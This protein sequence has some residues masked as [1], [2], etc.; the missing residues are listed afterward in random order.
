MQKQSELP[1]LSLT[2]ASLAIAMA[3][4]LFVFLTELLNF[5]Y[6][7]TIATSI[8]LLIV[9][10]GNKDAFRF[11]IKPRHLLLGLTS[12]LLLYG[13]FFAGFNIARGLSL[14]TEGARNVYAFR[15]G[16]PISII[17]A[18]LLFPISP[19]EEIFWRGLIQ[20]GL[21]LKLGSTTGYIAATLSYSLVHLPTFNAPLMLVALIGGLAWGF[22]YN[23]TKS[24]TPSVIS[25]L[26]F[27][28]MIFVLLP[29]A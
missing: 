2:L 28:E 5:W 9:L 16:L 15:S 7:L 3:L 4:W 18:L 19:A 22:L 27:N 17:G 10:A 8:F 1:G 13:F 20:K 29:I 25:H 26:I 12:G 23:R 11:D 6:R 21:V 14:I 24:L